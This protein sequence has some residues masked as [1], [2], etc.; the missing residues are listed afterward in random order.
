M[1]LVALLVP[2]LVCSL[3]DPVLGK[4]GCRG[5]VEAASLMDPEGWVGPRKGTE[6]ERM[7]LEGGAVSTRVSPEHMVCAGEQ[8]GWAD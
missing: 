7:S 2:I 6:E 8:L 4:K 5:S 3:G 1:L